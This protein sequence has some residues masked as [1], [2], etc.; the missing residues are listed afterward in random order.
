MPVIEKSVVTLRISGDTLVPAEITRLLGAPPTK[1]E[2]KGQ[3]IV[4][5]VT[6]HRRIAKSG[7][8][9]LCAADREPENMHE[10]IQELLS[11][12]TSDLSVWQKVADTFDIDLFCGVFMGDTNDG[13]VLS[14]KSLVALGQRHI[15]LQ[16][17]IYA[18]TEGERHART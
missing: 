12:L 13:L 6:G 8:W 14:P 16:L 18:P 15:E 5:D 2:T 11:Q 7:M 9:R 17:D 3:E 4:G 10:Q 1:A